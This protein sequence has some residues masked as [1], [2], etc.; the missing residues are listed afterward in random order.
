MPV[1]L[2][3]SSSSL[4]Y[5]GTLVDAFVLKELIGHGKIFALEPEGYCRSHREKRVELPIMI[6]G[7]A[8]ACPYHK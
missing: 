5:L 2:R 3:M 1:E 7:F 8:T 4:L 6:C